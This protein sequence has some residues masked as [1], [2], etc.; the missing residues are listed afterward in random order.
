M[1]DALDKLEP[2]INDFVA[3]KIDGICNNLGTFTNY[4]LNAIGSFG[5]FVSFFLDILDG[6]VDGFYTWGR[7]AE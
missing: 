3:S 6:S 4:L 1:V 5:T 2:Y 7:V